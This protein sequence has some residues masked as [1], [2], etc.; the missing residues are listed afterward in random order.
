MRI[1]RKIFLLK[2]IMHSTTKAYF[3]PK[4]NRYISRKTFIPTNLEI[5]FKSLTII[6]LFSFNIAYRPRN[7]YLKY[8]N[9]Y[10]FRTYN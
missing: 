3:S 4:L 6:F 8:L 9:I 10:L 5:D 1:L 2:H 7:F